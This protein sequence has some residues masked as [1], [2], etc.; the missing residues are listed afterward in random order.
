MR[1]PVRL[2]IRSTRPEKHVLVEV[3]LS[4]FGSS[5]KGGDVHRG[6]RFEPET[7]DVRRAPAIPIV[8]ALI[9]QSTDPG[10]RSG[11]D[12]GRQGHLRQQDRLCR[13]NY[14]ALKGADALVI[15]TEWRP[16][17]ERT[18]RGYE[19]LMHAGHLRQQR[20]QRQSRRCGWRIS[21]SDAHVEHEYVVI[22]DG[23]IGGRAVRTLV[24]AQRR[25]RARRPVGRP[26]LRYRQACRW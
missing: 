1:C 13:K 21:R 23:Y 18:A 25:R 10:L 12:E 8:E 15:V 19:K 2:S 17:R 20:R 7:T 3:N 5:L 4:R 24:E 26:R 11:S 16:L 14:D 22:E 9:G 6:W